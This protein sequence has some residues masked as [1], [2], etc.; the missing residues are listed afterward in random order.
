[1]ST[2]VPD[3]IRRD[4]TIDAPIATV[5]RLVSTPGWWINDGE[6]I[7]HE[8]TVDGDTT[9]LHW[10]GHDFPVRTLAV[11]QPNSVSFQWGSGRTEEPEG[12]RTRIDFTLAETDAGVVVTVVES[13]FTTYADADEATRTYDENVAGWEQELA[14]AKTVLER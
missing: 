2:T 8:T 7:E 1:M 9:T 10:N 4:I 3:T 5:W 6:I 11:D 13:G 14:A 12:P